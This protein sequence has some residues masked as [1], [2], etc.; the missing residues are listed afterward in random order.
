MARTRH[1]NAGAP[2]DPGLSPLKR[3]R[4]APAAV[5]QESANEQAAPTVPAAAQRNVTPDRERD[6]AVDAGADEDDNIDRGLDN[7]RDEDDGEAVGGQP[8]ET[9][10]KDQATIKA[11]NNESSVANERPAG[12]PSKEGSAAPSP[13]QIGRGLQSTFAAVG[14]EEGASPPRDRRP[15]LENSVSLAHER[16]A[17]QLGGLPMRGQRALLRQGGTHKNARSTK[18]SRM[19]RRKSE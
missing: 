11:G 10:N 2:L 14:A 8:E 17:K 16:N 6:N 9:T 15:T 13:R 12:R 7:L 5:A 3:T 1:Q 18:V 4:R 19:S